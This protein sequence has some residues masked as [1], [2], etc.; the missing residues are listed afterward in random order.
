MGLLV[1]GGF[2]LIGY[3]GALAGA[4]PD[5]TSVPALPVPFRGLVLAVLVLA[6]A[7]AA[8]VA[9]GRTGLI[10]ADARTAV[11]WVPLAL[12]ALHGA[13]TTVVTAALLVSP[14]RTGFL[15]GHALVTV[16]WTVAALVLLARGITRPALRAAGAVLV[17]AAV[18]KLVLFDLLA[19]DGLARVAAF[20]G[21]GL[22]LLAAG[23][24]YARL[25]ARGTGDGAGNGTRDQ[26]RR[27]E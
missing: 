10:R 26:E 5:P 13:T 15:A 6:A 12:V 21:A 23:H 17:A 7:V 11:L 14:D 19:L 9:A 3:L 8:L 1:G 22:V 2:A 18:G 27:E 25:V 4:L 24:R 16:S 20:L